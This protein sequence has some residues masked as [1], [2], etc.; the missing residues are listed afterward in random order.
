MR[1]FLPFDYSVLNLARRPLRT[2][3]TGL[4]SALVALLLVA[5]ASF[6][7]GLERSYEATAEDDT[8]ILLNAASQKDVIRSAVPLATADYVAADVRGVLR[9]DGVAAVSPEIHMATYVQLGAKPDSAA[10]DPRY[11]AFLRGVT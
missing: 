10:H 4:S 2:V 8:A 5:T 3:L 1:R 11:T 9:V 6:V 7:R